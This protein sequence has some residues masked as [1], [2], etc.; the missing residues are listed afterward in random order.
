MTRRPTRRTAAV[1][2][3]GVLAATCGGLAGVSFDPCY[4]SFCDNLTGDGQDEAIYDALQAEYDLVGNVNTKALD[5]N[6]D[7]IGS[8]VLTFAY[9]TST[10]NGVKPR[11]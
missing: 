5:I 10:V 4:H 3:A 9:D 8:A 7:V 1:A 6:A 2:S 11:R